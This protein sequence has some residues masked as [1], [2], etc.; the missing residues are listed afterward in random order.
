M[1]FMPEDAWKI[2]AAVVA[3]GLIGAEREFRDK[4]AGFRTIIFICLGAT[5]FTMLSQKLGG[6]V[7]PVR[8]AA[9]VVT[10]IGF[11][12]AGAILREG[13][14]VRGLTTAAAIW[15]SAALGMGIGGGYY[16]LVS[17]AIAASLVV[18]WFFPRFE[19]LIDRLS[20]SRTYEIT[21]R[22]SLDKLDDLEKAF[23]DAGVRY[24]MHKK[25]RIGE[26][27]TSTWE[28]RG[29]REAHENLVRMLF[30]DPEVDELRF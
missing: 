8:I 30:T 21:C 25:T 11:L 9:N 19:I 15:L 4:A 12:G 20:E 13:L 24:R 16:L 17:L 14:H 1:E 3:G 22:A 28:A 26:K 18:L 29:R 27:M 2:F 6:S 7:D 10:G 23:T 5:L